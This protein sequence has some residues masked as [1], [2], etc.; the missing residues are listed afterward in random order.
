MVVGVTVMMVAL[1]RFNGA[2]SERALEMS[3]GTSVRVSVDEAPVPM[4]D[5]CCRIAHS[6]HTVATLRHRQTVS[7]EG[8]RRVWENMSL[9]NP[10]WL[11]P[12][13][14]RSGNPDG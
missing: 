14:E 9:R 2:R 10:G 3:M 12:R 11:E 13:R 8:P 7:A 5:A 1:L 4:D 6:G